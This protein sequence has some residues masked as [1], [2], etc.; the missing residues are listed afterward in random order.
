MIVGNERRETKYGLSLKNKDESYY[1][2]RRT[3]KMHPGP[4]SSAGGRH[5]KKR[6]SNES[7]EPLKSAEICFLK[8]MHVLI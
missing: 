4:Y 3:E 7:T 8:E 5:V 6:S 1:C 2:R